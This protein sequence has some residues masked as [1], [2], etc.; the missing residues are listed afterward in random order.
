MF[1]ETQRWEGGE[2]GEFRLAFTL[3]LLFTL[4]SLDTFMTKHAQC[5]QQDPFTCALH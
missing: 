2:V 3:F 1:A 4:S 5:S